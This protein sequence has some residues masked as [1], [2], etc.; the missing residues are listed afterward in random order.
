MRSFAVL[1]EKL[2]KTPVTT[3]PEATTNTRVK[4]AKTSTDNQNET[5]VHISDS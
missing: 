1:A 2:V 3:V 4:P 5:K